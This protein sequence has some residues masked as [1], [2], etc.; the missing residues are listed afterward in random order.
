MNRFVFYG[1]KISIPTSDYNFSNSYIS[2]ILAKLEIKG[3]GNS[4]DGNY[5]DVHGKYD[6]Y[7][8]H[9]PDKQIQYEIKKVVQ[10]L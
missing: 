6:Y 4:V 7:I 1:L 9:A 5:V 8:L 10:L 3:K 2:C